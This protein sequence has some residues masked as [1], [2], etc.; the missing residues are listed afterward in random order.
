VPVRLRKAVMLV[1]D[2][3][4]RR[5]ELYEV[6]KLTRVDVIS[7]TDSDQA[8]ALVRREHPDL[9]VLN[10][11]SDETAGIDF[12]KQLRCFGLGQKMIV[13]GMVGDEDDVL[14][15]AASMAGP[16]KLL[17][18][19]P[20]PHVVLE[21]ILAYLDIEQ[22]EVPENMQA[23]VGSKSV[24]AAPEVALTADEAGEVKP[25]VRDLS[26]LLRLTDDAGKKK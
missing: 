26:S 1:E 7:A 14:H 22:I 19:S 20:A 5:R 2:D 23:E 10:M 16:D 11:F 3:P 6:L 8:M 9:I 18:R 12:L 17:E 4:A 25:I 21:L 13:L 15:K 24:E